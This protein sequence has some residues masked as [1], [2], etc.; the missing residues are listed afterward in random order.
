[1]SS[2]KIP[3]CGNVID[4]NDDVIDANGD[5]I[6]A[7][8]NVIDANGLIKPRVIISCFRRSNFLIRVSIAHLAY[9]CTL[10]LAMQHK[11]RSFDSDR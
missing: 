3:H 2:S 8:G 10:V 11:G 4:A 7:N 6:D 5:V 1:M 9:H